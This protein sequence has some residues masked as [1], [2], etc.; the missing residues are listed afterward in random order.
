MQHPQIR[1]FFC[2]T[3]RSKCDC[4]LFC[5]HFDTDLEKCLFDKDACF[6][7]RGALNTEEVAECVGTLDSIPTALAVTQTRPCSLVIGGAGY[8]RRLHIR[9][10]VAWWLESA[11][12]LRSRTRL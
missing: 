5:C 4:V 10:D 3:F 7:L 2:M 12:S 9:R 11:S 8:R 6:L 1:D